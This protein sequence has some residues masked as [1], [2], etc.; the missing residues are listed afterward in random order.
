ML[1]FFDSLL[2]FWLI[3]STNQHA[4]KACVN[5]YS[6][7]VWYMI[8]CPFILWLRQKW[9]V[10]EHPNPMHC[11]SYVQWASECT[12]ALLGHLSVSLLCTLKCHYN[13]FF[14]NSV[15]LSEPVFRQISGNGLLEKCCFCRWGIHS[16]LTPSPVNH[17]ILASDNGLII[18][19][20]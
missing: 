16:K 15:Q 3:V 17:Q 9:N 19:T 12:L 20:Q 10:S 14:L 4:M 2:Q 13:I 18:M 8:L 7:W 5:A 1:K 6:L 11:P